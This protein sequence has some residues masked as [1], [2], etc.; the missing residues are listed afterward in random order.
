MTMGFK[1]EEEIEE[2]FT[3]EKQRLE[4]AFLNKIN[5]DK[6]NIPKYREEFNAELKRLIARYEAE[7]D[8]LL[9]K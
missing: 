3:I 8:K 1:T 7:Y 6:E 4:T 5:K 2:W 9:S